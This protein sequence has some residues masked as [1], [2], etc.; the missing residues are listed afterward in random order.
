M[1]NFHTRQCYC[2]LFPRTPCTWTISKSKLIPWGVL[3]LLIVSHP[4]YVSFANNDVG[5]SFFIQ[6]LIIS[7][8]LDVLKYVPYCI[9]VYLMRCIQVVTNNTKC[10]VL[11]GQNGFDRSFFNN[12]LKNSQG[13]IGHI[14]L[15]Y[16]SWG[17][18]GEQS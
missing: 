9:H 10:I 1:L 12:M 5:I 2:R 16:L 6:Y 4:I 7:C 8:A 3:F 18:K 11:F 14:F 17:H 15:H 13:L